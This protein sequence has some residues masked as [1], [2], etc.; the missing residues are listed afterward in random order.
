[1]ISLRKPC[2][3]LLPSYFSFIEDMRLAGETIWEG[4]TRYKSESDDE[5]LSRINLSETAP[6]ANMVAQTNFWAWNGEQVVGRIALRHELNENLKEFGGHIGYEVRPSAR[7]HGLAKEMLRLVLLTDEAQKMGRVLL[8]CA[9]SNEASNRT[10]VANGGVLEKTAYVE[11]IQRDTNYYWIMIKKLIKRKAA[12]AVLL[13]SQNEI[14]LIKISDPSGTWSG[15]ITP[16]G[17][18]DDN[19]TDIQSL[20]RELKEELGYT[21]PFKA[22]KLWFRTTRFTWVNEN[23]EQTETFY[24][25]KTEKFEV[26]ESLEL[27]ESEKAGFK[28]IKWWRLEE[29]AKSS[30]NFA[31]PRFYEL[32]KDILDR[33]LPPVPINLDARSTASSV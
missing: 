11:R 16:G 7:G 32:L 19:E 2:L 31:P 28:D 4:M 5:F 24:L 29:I 20:A 6:P 12:R 14:L 3:E 27:T 18:I 17:G 8:T 30:D 23:Y 26:A 1:M 25:L 10:I 22:E 13:T 33:G 21:Q 9:P 15:W